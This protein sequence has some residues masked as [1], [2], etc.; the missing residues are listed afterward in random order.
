MTSPV[1]PAHVSGAPLDTIPVP[2]P[3]RES[4][5]RQSTI[6]L[7]NRRLSS[8]SSQ[9]NSTST[10]MTRFDRPLPKAIFPLGPPR[11]YP[12]DLTP[13]NSR[14]RPHCHAGRCLLEW[15]VAMEVQPKVVVFAPENI[16]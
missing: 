4:I 10:N 11:P 5:P 15:L 9:A 13:L 7:L 1:S 8:D 12:K 16:Q 14:L 2:P 3:P 6:S